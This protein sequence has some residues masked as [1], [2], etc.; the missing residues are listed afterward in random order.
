MNR[1][2][3]AFREALAQ[4]QF[5]TVLSRE[6][7]VRRFEAALQ[8]APVGTEAVPLAKALGRVLADNVAAPVDVPPFDR[9]AVDGF[10]V[11]SAD[12]AAAGET[13]PV[14]LSLN[15]EIVACGTAPKLIVA[16]GTATAIATGGPIPR[17]ADAVVMVEHTDPEE[18]GL[19]PAVAIRRSAAPG[20][21]IG[22]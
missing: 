3:N 20:Q 21:F 18:G 11:R 1:P 15:D 22:F 5:L 7:A 6:E 14:I 4:E 12:I 10:A 16:P 17:G 19:T 9:S 13:S 2:E 8:P